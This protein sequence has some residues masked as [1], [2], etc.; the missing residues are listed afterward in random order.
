MRDVMAK[1]RE[2]GKYAK[3]RDFPHDCGTV[4]TYAIYLCL[5]PQPHML[6][7]RMTAFRVLIVTYFD[8]IEEFM[9]PGNC[10][11]CPHYG[12]QL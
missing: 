4:D 12:G 7:K 8:A 5:I 11:K 6:S 1:M 10:Y 9:H 3:M 2:C